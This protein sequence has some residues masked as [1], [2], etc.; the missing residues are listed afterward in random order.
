MCMVPFLAAVVSFGVLV[1]GPAT[2][3]SG[4]QETPE[5]LFRKYFP[6][7]TGTNGFE[8]YLQAADIAQ[9]P[10]FASHSAFFARIVAEAAGQPPIDDETGRPLPWPP[11][12]AGLSPSSSQLDVQRQ[13]V[14]ACGRILDLV[15]TGNTKP[16]FDPRATFDFESTFPE[17]SKFR[18]V[19]RFLSMAAYVRFADGSSASGTDALLQALRFADAVGGLTMI[20]TLVQIAMQAIVMTQFSECL[21]Q[22][23]ESDAKRIVAD[24]GALLSRPSSLASALERERTMMLEGII[25]AKPSELI[26]LFGLS[27]DESEAQSADFVKRLNSNQWQQVK[28]IVTSRLGRTYDQALQCLR[29]PET[30]WAA[31]M[32]STAGIEPEPPKSVSSLD[33][34]ADHV[35]DAAVPSLAQLFVSAARIRTQLRL[36]RLHGMLI[37]FRWHHRRLPA[38]LAD[39]VGPGDL[40]DPF[41]GEPFQY[42]L[43]AG[44]Y[45]LFSKGFANTGEI[46]LRYQRPVSSGSDPNDPPSLEYLSQ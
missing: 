11:A 25:K 30:Q 19:A 14:K 27:F 4:A 16:A 6:K 36:L 12:P 13:W 24:V 44:G 15:K 23:S 39:A 45:R 1:S 2:A 42:Q 7:P 41:S 35:V 20:H 9:S 21:P 8:E 32:E 5:S 34:V 37:G 31:M 10:A 26:E 40:N 18:S 46:E 28:A 3:I 43:L 22:L 33:D 17:L 38:R 29:G